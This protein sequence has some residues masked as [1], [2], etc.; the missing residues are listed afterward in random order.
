MET[1]KLTEAR[2]IFLTKAGMP[3]KEC[4]LTID[5]VCDILD[6]PISED[7][8]ER[9]YQL[10]VARSVMSGLKKFFRQHH[11]LFVNPRIEKTVYYGFTS[12]EG[13]INNSIDRAHKMA[14]AYK[15]I[16]KSAAMI[17]SG[18]LELIP[19]DN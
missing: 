3:R 18:Q 2:E 7:K 5:D 19:F 8:L 15:A 11:I 17:A 6:K 1:I 16:E 14:I 10:N 9:M 13:M 4:M 12:D